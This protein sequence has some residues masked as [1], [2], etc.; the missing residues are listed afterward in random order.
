VHP[1][2]RGGTQPRETAGSVEL[3]FPLQY[4]QFLALSGGRF[5]G[6]VDYTDW[7][8]AEPGSG[9]F[10]PAAGPHALVFTFAGTQ[11][12]HILNGGLRAGRCHLEDQRPGHRRQGQGH[13]HLQRDA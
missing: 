12:S 3:G 2:P 1:L 6:D 5:H 9:V 7:T 10:A 4:E 13:D 8:S 11:Y